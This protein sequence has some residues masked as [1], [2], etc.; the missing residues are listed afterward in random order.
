[1]LKMAELS[2]GTLIA[3]VPVTTRCPGTPRT[4]PTAVVRKNSAKQ[5][6]MAFFIV[7]QLTEGATGC[8]LTGD[9]LGEGI[10]I[11]SVVAVSS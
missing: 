6:G 3:K 2:L 7:L 11:G 4:I 8:E 5:G 10:M 9:G 1:M